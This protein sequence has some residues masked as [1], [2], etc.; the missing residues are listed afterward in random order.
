MAVLWVSRG[1]RK[2]TDP[3]PA[4]DR[5]AQPA[6]GGA[7]HAIRIR[8][9]ER[10]APANGT[11]AR[12]IRQTHRSESRLT[13]GSGAVGVAT[14]TQGR[15]DPVA[16]RELIQAQSALTV[17]RLGVDRTRFADASAARLH[18][19]HAQPA[20]RVAGALWATLLMT[21]THGITGAVG[22]VVDGC[23]GLRPTADALSRCLGQTADGVTEG[24]EAGMV[25]ATSAGATFAVRPARSRAVAAGRPAQRLLR[26]GNGR[27]AGKFV[28]LAGDADQWEGLYLRAVAI[29]DARATHW[30]H[31]RGRLERGGGLGV[32]LGRCG[33]AL[34]R[35]GVRRRLGRTRVSARARR[36]RRPALTAAEVSFSLRRAPCVGA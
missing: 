3:L 8:V 16:G 7:A 32:T 17:G 20:A 24:T 12:I 6:H 5:R 30:A 26:T 36:A 28:R 14:A 34:G 22:S 19:G 35:I 27:D 11:R 25:Y 21:A 13:R 10:S 33:V 15:A 1:R 4:C 18:L 29:L 23:A 9:A 31:R 2:V